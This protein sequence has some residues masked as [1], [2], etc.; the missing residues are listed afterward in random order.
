[1][2]NV[3]KII[4]QNTFKSILKIIHYKI[5]PNRIPVAKRPNIQNFEIYHKLLLGKKGLEIGG[6]SDIF[7]RKDEL[8]IYPIIKQ[9]DGCNFSPKTIWEGEIKQGHTYIYHNKNKP[10]YQ[11][12]C[13]ASELSTI[14]SETYDFV[15]SSHSIE[16]IANPLKAITNWLKVLKKGGA[17][18]MVVPNKENTFDHRRPVTTL[19]HLIE[20]FNN[21]VD[22]HDLTHL[23]EILQLHDLARDPQAGS[24]SDFEKRSYQ[25]Y[26]NRCLHHHVF[27]AG[28]VIN[29]YSYFNI[30]IK[31]MDLV[32]PCHIIV[33]GIKQKNKADNS[34]FL[35]K[36]Q[37]YNPVK[38]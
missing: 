32:K 10:G 34:P 17:L 35:A 13:E 18:L 16:H 24:F 21:D 6:P 20:D 4:K 38:E 27:D 3:V 14:P 29:L 19:H 25:N 12:I 9:L 2:V 23:P 26:E 31:A 11:F 28:L 8:P 7:R 30:Q 5:F 1:M 22:E 36:Y 37:T 33:I 15:L